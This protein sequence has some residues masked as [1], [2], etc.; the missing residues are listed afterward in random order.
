MDDPIPLLDTT[1]RDLD[2]FLITG[3]ATFV[4]VKYQTK[5]SKNE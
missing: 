3:N 1:T 2:T 4:S 5:I